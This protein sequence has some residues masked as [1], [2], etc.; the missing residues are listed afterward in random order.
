VEFFIQSR[1]D[2]PFFLFFRFMEPKEEKKEKSFLFCFCIVSSPMRT[3]AGVRVMRTRVR[4]RA[5]LVNLA[6]GPLFAYRKATETA[7]LP[8]REA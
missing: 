3:G 2:P 8:L 1:V 5:Q 4:A 7:G 6:A